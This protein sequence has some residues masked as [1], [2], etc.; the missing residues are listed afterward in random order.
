MNL[1]RKDWASKQ[2]ILDEVADVPDGW[3]RGF[4]VRHP[5]D[6]RKFHASR[7]GAMLYRVEAVLKAI[8]D[9]E[10]MPDGGIVHRESAEGG[11][12]TA[13]GEG[14][15]AELAPRAQDKRGDGCAARVREQT[16]R[17]DAAPY[18]ADKA[19]GGIQ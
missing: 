4:A 12:Q 11:V 19:K 3:L 7:N 18:R 2:A 17:R 15:D 6:C 16:A 1:V 9:G 13:E 10:T 5:M 8:E 14:N